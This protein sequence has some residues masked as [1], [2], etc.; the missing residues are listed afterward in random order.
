MVAVIASQG[1][2]QVSSAIVNITVTDANDNQPTFEAPSYR[3]VADIVTQ[4][5]VEVTA[6][7]ML[8]LKAKFEENDSTNDPNY[9]STFMTE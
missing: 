1:A 7:I 3:S 6:V 8:Q 9:S 2:K 5:L 4:V